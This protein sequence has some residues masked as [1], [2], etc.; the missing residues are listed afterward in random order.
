MGNEMFRDAYIYAQWR[1]GLIP[2]IYLQ[3]EEYF[4]EFSD[5]IK[6]RFTPGIGF[7]PKVGIHVR[8]GSNPDNPN[9]PEYANNPFYVDLCAT[10]YYERAMAMFPDKEFIVVSDDP[11]FCRQRFPDLE[12]AEGTELEDFNLLASCEHQIIANSSFSWWAGYLNKNPNKIVVAPK[13][14]HPDGVER[15]KLP[16]SWTII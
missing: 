13:D 1:K 6:Q 14:W 9:E 4:K 11:Q 12:V 8:R 15:T 3:D 16:N 5:E 2:D 7:E 10:D